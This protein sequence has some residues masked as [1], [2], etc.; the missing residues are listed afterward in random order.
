MNNDNNK[1]NNNKEALEDAFFKR[2][3]NIS[4]IF[5]ARSG[6]YT[7]TCQVPAVFSQFH[8]REESQA[9]GLGKQVQSR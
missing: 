5:Y 2:R 7:K 1:D 8:S 9:A 4:T 6:D 3:K